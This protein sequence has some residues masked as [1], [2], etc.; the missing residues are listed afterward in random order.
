MS[1][2]QFCASVKAETVATTKQPH[3][4]SKF[5]VGSSKS[6]KINFSQ[7]QKVFHSGDVPQH[8]VDA[9]RAAIKMKQANILGTE[10]REWHPSTISD[11]KIQKDTDLDLKRQLLKG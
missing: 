11:Q 4:T 2:A 10:P 8:V 7:A 9:K 6:D 5:Q 1:T 3:L